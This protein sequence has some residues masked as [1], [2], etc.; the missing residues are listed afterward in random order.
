MEF[1]GQENANTIKTYII[2][3]AFTLKN[4]ALFL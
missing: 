2:N 1:V 3:I 4:K